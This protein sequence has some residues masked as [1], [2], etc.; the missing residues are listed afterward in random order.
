[1]KCK[2]IQK[3]LAN[4]V[5]EVLGSEDV[6][7]VQEHIVECDSC[8]HQVDMLRKV[9]NLID[10]VR[11]EYPPVSVWD[12]FIPDLH[13]RIESE[14]ALTFRR[15]W[16]Q[17][18]YFV[19]GWM[20]VAAMI[21]MIISTS[22]LIKHY[23]SGES[24]PTQEA[25]VTEKAE[26]NPQFTAMDSSESLLVAGL[27]SEVFITDA[28]AEELKNLSQL[29]TLTTPYQYYDD[30]MIDTDTEASSSEGKGELIESLL[31]DEFIDFGEMPIESDEDES[32]M[33]PINW[34]VA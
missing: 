30:I 7:L 18:I 31:E 5:N 1:V 24:A 14:A 2:R 17:R 23:P 34:T 11:I 16:W 32:I 4:Y 22:V 27:I 13:K 8:R 6:K 10:N 28:Q 25:N 19:P 3:M 15:Q 26:T 20:A 21:M 33:Y 29:E 9:L 12:R